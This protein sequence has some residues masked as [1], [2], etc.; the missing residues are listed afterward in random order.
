[1]NCVFSVCV[2]VCVCVCACVCICRIHLIIL[3]FPV[4]LDSVAVKNIKE[5]FYVRQ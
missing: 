4:I 1:M 5:F 3:L 2:C